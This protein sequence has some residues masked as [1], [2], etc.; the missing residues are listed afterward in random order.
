MYKPS[1]AQCSHRLFSKLRIACNN[2]FYAFIKVKLHGYNGGCLLAFFW[3]CLNVRPT[4]WFGEN[5]VK[6][7]DTVRRVWIDASKFLRMVF[8]NDGVDQIH[9][10]F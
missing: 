9:S 4:T 6:R 1:S 2:S 10:K 3:P 8:V 7:G 5:I